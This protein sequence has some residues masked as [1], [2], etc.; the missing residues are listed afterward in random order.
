[1]QIKTP[2]ITPGWVYRVKASDEVVYKALVWK[3]LANS[4]FLVQFLEPLENK[5][6]AQLEFGDKEEVPE[7]SIISPY[8]HLMMRDETDENYMEDD[9]SNQA[10]VAIDGVDLFI[11]PRVIDPDNAPDK[12]ELEYTLVLTDPERLGDKAIT[13]TV[14][15]PVEGLSRVEGIQWPSTRPEE[16][17]A[18]VYCRCYYGDPRPIITDNDASATDL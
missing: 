11:G 8:A 5:E 2:K 9:I 15:I 3:A 10:T 1:M 14:H 13:V 18:Q 17:S 7:G 4:M 6:E 12:G 16:D